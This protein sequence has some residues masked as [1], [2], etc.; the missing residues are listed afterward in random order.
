LVEAR[1]TDLAVKRRQ[2]EPGVFSKLLM[3]PY[4]V[5]VTPPGIYVQ[6]RRINDRVAMHRRHVPVH[7][8]LLAAVLPLGWWFGDLNDHERGFLTGAADPRRMAYAMGR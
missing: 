4:A 5:L 6:L 8:E 2:W 1:D 7:N 3:R